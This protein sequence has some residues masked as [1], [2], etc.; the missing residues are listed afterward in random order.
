[1][2]HV[3]LVVASDP[4]RSTSKKMYVASV[5]RSQNLLEKGFPEELQVIAIR[6]AEAEYKIALFRKKCG[7]L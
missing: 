5:K 3:I 2:E 7:L 1:M 6:A 4:P